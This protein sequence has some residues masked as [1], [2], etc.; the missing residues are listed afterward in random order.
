MESV[1][2]IHDFWARVTAR[3][4]YAMVLMYYDVIGYARSL[5]VLRRKPPETM[6]GDWK[7]VWRD[8]LPSAEM[9]DDGIGVHGLSL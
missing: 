3:G 8:A 1:V 6:P 4:R 5:V 7:T 2:F 9:V